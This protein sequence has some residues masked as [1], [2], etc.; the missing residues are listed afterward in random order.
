M[1]KLQ[2]KVRHDRKLSKEDDLLQTIL[3][4]A[5][6][7][8][9][10]EFLNVKYKHTH[11]PMLLKNMDLAIELLH[12]S[13]GEGKTIF[14]KVDCDVDG[15][16]SASYMY[17]FIKIISPETKVVYEISYDKE[18]G[19]YFNDL[20]KHTNTDLVIVPD[21]GS[22]NIEDCQ[23]ITEQLNIP[24]L[25]L[26]HH[27][28]N[29]PQIHQY[30]TVVNCT[31]GQ[32]PNSTLTGVGVV[33]KFCMGYCKQY[34]L[35]MQICDGFLD[36]VALGMV[37]DS[38]DM[39]N[40]ETRYYT[41]EGLNE[42]NR[43]NEFINELAISCKDDMKFGHTI[44]NYGWKLAPKINAVVRYGK[45]EEQIDLF[46]AMCGE[47][48]D[49]E[50]QPRRERGSGKNSPKPPI[51]IHSLQKTMARVCTNVKQ[52]QDKEVNEFIS[53]L[54]QTIK[55]QNLD[56][57]SV[58]MIDATKVLTKK[59]VTGLVANKLASKYCRPIVILKEYTDTL[60]GG[61]GRGYDKG[62]VQDFNDFLSGLGVFN[63]CA[64]HANAFG[65]EIQ[66]DKVQEAI[67]LCNERLK[68]SDLVT[69]H[70]V[71]YEVDANELKNQTVLQ[72][73]NSYAIWG[74][75]VEEPKFA[76]TNIQIP[77]KDI[78]GYGD[79]NG[80]IRFKYNNV[81][82][83]KKYCLKTDFDDMTLKDRN[84]LGANKKM[85]H[86]NLIG[87]FVLNEYEGKIYPQVKIHQ[88][89]SSEFKRNKNNKNDI[90]DDFIF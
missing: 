1:D 30:A 25:I 7:E 80:F 76:I 57:N 72:V 82:Y 8:N 66:K 78:C 27:I 5:G 13:L 67:S 75:H 85:L 34:G 74:N 84:T 38:A 29:D 81:D 20:K 45:P 44:T 52:R 37:A 47:K 35:N 64:G 70:E 11:D 46:R 79:N 42:D 59:T 41:L 60:Y 48:D 21:A 39:R 68:L 36:L 62:K 31:D 3:I 87:S 4:E 86:M 56:R 17:Q 12:G 33:H 24:I 83:I 69:I 73:A 28:I 63:K 51:E 89:E 77:A 10:E 53:I 43:R 14:I 58:I 15:F 16:T 40:L 50:Y 32:Y 23:K 88:Y 49:R 19:I 55:D 22:D 54:D 2:W 6:I 71:D 26:D 61:S 65:I 9:I 90:D 18:H